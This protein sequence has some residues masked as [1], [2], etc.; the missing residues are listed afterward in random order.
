L[1]NFSANRR[2]AGAL[3]LQ[4]GSGPDVADSVGRR[5]PS[6]AGNRSCNSPDH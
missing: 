3:R 1:S 5:R 6:D 2:R 4:E